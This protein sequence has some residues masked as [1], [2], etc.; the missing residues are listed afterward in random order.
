MRMAL[1]TAGGPAGGP[2]HRQQGQN[3]APTGT[4]PPGPFRLVSA[5]SGMS[6]TEGT[7]CSCRSR[8]RLCMRSAPPPPQYVRGDGSPRPRNRGSSSPLMPVGTREQSLP[9]RERVRDAIATHRQ[10]RTTLP[11]GAA[12]RQRCWGGRMQSADG[13]RRACVARSRCT[14]GPSASAAVEDGCRART[15][16]GVLVSRDRDAPATAHVGTFCK[17]C[18]H[19]SV[20]T[21]RGTAQAPSI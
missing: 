8:G 21:S 2:A 6:A 10:Q 7:G 5:K 14:S 18:C 11:L 15:A 13:T 17:F 1:S 16:R 9:A 3:Q 19:I 12:L 4:R 20:Q